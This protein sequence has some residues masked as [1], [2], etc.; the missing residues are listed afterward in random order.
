MKKLSIEEKIRSVEQG[1]KNEAAVYAIC[2]EEEIHQIV[3]KN[4]Y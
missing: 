1:L 2:R 4:R 3:I